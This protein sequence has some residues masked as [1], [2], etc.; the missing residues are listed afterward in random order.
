MYK[1][2]LEFLFPKPQGKLLLKAREILWQLFKKSKILL[3]MHKPWNAHE[4]VL[5]ILTKDENLKVAFGRNRST[6][7]R[8]QFDTNLKWEGG[9]G[10]QKQNRSFCSIWLF[11]SRSSKRTCRQGISSRK[12]YICTASTPYTKDYWLHLHNTCNRDHSPNIK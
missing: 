1:R 4:V 2:A 7:M 12:D 5:Q 10:P 11:S 9:P 3:G 6:I 8:M